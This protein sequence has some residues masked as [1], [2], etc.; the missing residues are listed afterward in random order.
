MF[1]QLLAISSLV[2]FVLG[3]I[4]GVSPEN[5]DL[6][7]PIIE[8]GKQYWRC[9]ND[10]SIRLTYDQ[11]NDNFAIAPMDLT[12]QVPMLALVLHLNSIVQTRV[13][14]QISLINLK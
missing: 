10:S 1:Q 5:Q 9:L 2:T 11:I 3:E 13:I 4:R 6:Y 7:K 12:N 8:N 14:S